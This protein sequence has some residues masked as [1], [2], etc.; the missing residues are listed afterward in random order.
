MFDVITFGSA[1]RDVY[2]KFRKSFL[3]LKENV[4][5]KNIPFLGNVCFILGSK[6]DVEDVF[7][8]FGGGGTNSAVTFAKQGFKTAFCGA[9][10][11]DI[12]GKII[13]D[14]LK[15]Y[16]IDT[17]FIVKKKGMKSGYS[18]VLGEQTDRIILAY[19]GA[20]K[21]L[22]IKDVNVGKMRAKWF[23]L[24][25]LSGYS[26]GFARKIF[27]YAIKKG[28]KVAINPSKDLINKY[29]KWIIRVSSKIDVLIL[30]KEELCSLLGKS[31][32]INDLEI[33]KY[34]DEIKITPKILIVTK[35]EDGASVFLRDKILTARALK[36]K[37][38]DKTGAGDAFGSGF[39]SGL[40][41][42]LDI[43]ESLQ[44]AT[45]NSA[46]CITKVGAH[47]GTLLANSSYKKVKVKEINI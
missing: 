29:K 30:N 23:Y 17:K 14:E 42:G 38:V 19:R 9:V 16:K 26:C 36:V 10:G 46:G 3:D 32:V 31:F 21:Y 6:V 45:A 27:D 47:E 2:L 33:K 18:V 35:G 43:K 40:L 12:R 39:V 28:I 20:S 8:T 41:K 1:T 15:K 34:I 44:L 22:D 37:I 25:P 4:K 13:V 24:A 7:F 11:D 5:A